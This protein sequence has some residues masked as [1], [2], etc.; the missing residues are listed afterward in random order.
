MIPRPSAHITGDIAV[1]RAT[2]ITASVGLIHIDS[3]IEVDSLSYKILLA[4]SNPVT[5]RIAIYTDNG[6]R[7]INVTDSP[8]AATGQRNVAVSPAVMLDPGH[9]Y[10]FYSRTSGATGP[11]IFHFQTQNLFTSPGAGDFDLEGVIT[12]VGGAA[13]AIFGF[14]GITATAVDRTLIL[15]LDGVAS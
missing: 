13:P 3:P 11:A 7:V 4:G 9:Y 12:V 1:F 6:I 2:D 10:T 8:N 5:I 15:R 14:T